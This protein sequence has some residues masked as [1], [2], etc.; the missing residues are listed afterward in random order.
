[1]YGYP[2]TATWP[3]SSSSSRG[4]NQPPLTMGAQYQLAPFHA[5]PFEPPYSMEHGYGNQNSTN[6]SPLIAGNLVPEMQG[7]FGPLFGILLP[8]SC[9]RPVGVGPV[10]DANRHGSHSNPSM[11]SRFPEPHQGSCIPV[12][13]LPY[14]GYNR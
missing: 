7:I 5:A 11:L 3:D 1:M 8:D 13:D 10:A 2:F 4:R 9:A 6:L 14:G 12:Q